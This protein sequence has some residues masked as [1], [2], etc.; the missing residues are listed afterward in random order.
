MS[1]DLGRTYKNG[2]IVCREGDEGDCMFVIQAGTVR[3]SKDTPSGE[4][5]I[6]TLGEGEIFGEM[7]LFDKLPR[8]ATV[9]A[10][11]DTR[12]LTIDKDKLFSNL[13]RDPTLAFKIIQS[14]SARTRLLNEEF[15]KLKKKRMEFLKI[16]LSITD[17]CR[18]ILE[19]AREMV[20]A[21][22][23]SIM[24]L[25]DEKESLVIRAAF[26]AQKENK[27]ALRRGEGIAGKALETGWSEL[28]NNVDLDPRFKAG[29]LDVRSI[30]C[31]PLR[32]A[33]GNFGVINLSNVSERVFT[34][35][36]L[37]F[38]KAL[39]TYA[40]I[41]IQNATSL[42]GIKDATESLIHYVSSL[43]I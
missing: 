12:L 23:G 10:C 41:A 11:G 37:R 15:I 38:V 4:V 29:G 6:A 18:E 36:D 21:E 3:V 17:T 8:S 33:E 26:G 19:E 30:I 32:S 7:A 42:S 5:V 2:E 14:M 31:V 13:S 1:D 39:S 34:K 16:G 20:Q 28:V 25:D 35:E 43:E 22:N 24:L 40:S 27:A 9:S